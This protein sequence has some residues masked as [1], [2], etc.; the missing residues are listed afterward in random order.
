MK[1]VKGFTLIELMIV[2]AII[3]ILAAIAIPNFLKFQARAK[4]SEAKQNLGAIF[5]AYTSYFSDNNTF[6]SAATITIASNPYNCLNVADWQPTGQL[7]YEFMCENSVAY[8]PGWN[9]GASAP[10]ACTPAFPVAPT[11]TQVSFTVGA[12]G[13]IDN[14]TTLDE[15]TVNTIKVLNNVL[16][17]V[18]N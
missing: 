15:W 9:T 10:A 13:N 3:G 7:R 12:C 2:V 18:K 14:D 5:T 4:Q 1:K 16:D 17:D 11:G 8:Y 6:P